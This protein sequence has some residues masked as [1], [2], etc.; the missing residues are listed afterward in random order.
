MRSGDLS[1]IAAIRCPAL[2]LS[3]SSMHISYTALEEL[4]SLLRMAKVEHPK[5]PSAGGERRGFEI[6]R[7]QVFNLPITVTRPNP[8]SLKHGNGIES[9]TALNLFHSDSRGTD[10]A[11]GGHELRNDGGLSVHGCHSG[12]QRTFGSHHWSRNSQS[13]LQK[14]L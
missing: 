14:K 5:E 6:P 2:S 3:P 10:L 11:Q 9:A 8:S 1:G 4:L 13:F 12:D 7:L